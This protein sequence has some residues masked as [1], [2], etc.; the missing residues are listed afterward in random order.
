VGFVTNAAIG[1]FGAIA[2]HDSLTKLV[3]LRIAPR[4]IDLATAFD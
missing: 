1:V 3:E 2:R 4:D